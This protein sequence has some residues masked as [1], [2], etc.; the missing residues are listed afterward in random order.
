MIMTSNHTFISHRRGT[1]YGSTDIVDVVSTCISRFKIEECSASSKAYDVVFRHG[2][3]QLYDV[4][5]AMLLAIFS[6]H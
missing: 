3:S 4:H 1:C 2:W 6:S 5:I